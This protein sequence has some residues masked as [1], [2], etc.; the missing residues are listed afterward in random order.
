M[1]AG[2][3]KTAASPN[4]PRDDRPIDEFKGVHAFLSNFHPCEVVLVGLDGLEEAY[5]SVEHAFQAMKTEDPEQRRAIRDAPLPTQAK[6]LGRRAALS[7]ATPTG[8]RWIG[9]EGWEAVRLAVMI[10]ALRA[11]FRDP[12]LRRKLI[13]TGERELIERNSWGDAIWG[14]V[15]AG[16]AWIGE[17]L[18]GQALMQ[19]R[20][21]LR[22]RD[23]D[24]RDAR[25]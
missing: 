5:P 17:N 9:R 7:G 3:T 20:R 12:D 8:S 10:D 23:R 18:L 1:S 15:R 16:G 25:G 19:V 21:E 6:R 4:D 11:K 24:A 14:K 22:D 2:V 13:E